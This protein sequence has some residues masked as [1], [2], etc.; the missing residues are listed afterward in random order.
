MTKVTAMTDFVVSDYT[1][2]LQVRREEDGVSGSGRFDSAAIE[3]FVK[4]LSMALEAK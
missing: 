2:H 4:V 1:C 3:D